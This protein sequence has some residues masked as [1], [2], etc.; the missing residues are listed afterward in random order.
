MGQRDVVTAVN[1]QMQLLFGDVLQSRGKTQGA[2]KPDG[3]T[4]AEERSQVRRKVVGDI[5]KALF[6][7]MDPPCQMLGDTCIVTNKREGSQ[8]CND[9]SFKPRNDFADCRRTVFG[10]EQL[11]LNQRRE[12]FVFKLFPNRPVDTCHDDWSYTILQKE[13]PGQEKNRARRTRARELV[14]HQQNLV[15]FTQVF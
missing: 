5:G 4:C 1:Q 15:L 9:D 12:P 7:F 14:Q 13:C 2:A 6:F 10:I 8:R 3:L 11:W